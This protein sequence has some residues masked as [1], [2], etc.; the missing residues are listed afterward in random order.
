MALTPTQDLFESR[1][2]TPSGSP[3]LLDRIYERKRAAL[4]DLNGTADAPPRR[5]LRRGD[6]QENSEEKVSV[7]RFTLVSRGAPP[8]RRQPA[9]HELLRVPPRDSASLGMKFTFA[10]VQTATNMV[11]AD[12]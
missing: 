7:Q 8:V 1:S 6:P 9:Q 11:F 5:R 4:V 3:G 12:G 2:S 10:A